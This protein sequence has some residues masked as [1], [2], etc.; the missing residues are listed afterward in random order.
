[1][2]KTQ[3]PAKRAK[4]DE[5][6]S[7]VKGVPANIGRLTAI[8]SD[9]ELRDKI[10]HYGDDMIDA[11]VVVYN[12]RAE[13]AS[14]TLIAYYDIGETVLP[15]FKAHKKG[16]AQ[17]I[18]EATGVPLGVL[19]ASM[20]TAKTYNR[21]QIEELTTRRGKNGFIATWSHV[22]TLAG[23]EDDAA[24]ERLCTQMFAN[25]WAVDEL[26]AHLPASGSGR[27]VNATG[28]TPSIPASPIACVQGLVSRLTASNNYALVL[29]EENDDGVT[30]LQHRFSDV[31]VTDSSLIASLEAAMTAVKRNVEVN[32]KAA[33]V[34]SN[35]LDAA[36]NPPKKSDAKQAALPAPDRATAK[37]I[38]TVKPVAPIKVTRAKAEQAAPAAPSVS[39]AAAAA[40]AAAKPVRKRAFD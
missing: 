25:A 24:R 40:A 23:V 11:V 32:N 20:A 21:D 14:N 22:H 4:R 26:Q 37:G 33:S 35:M 18:C 2:A 16:G 34:I 17:V 1:V 15:V 38:K 19:Y 12:R 29:L 6:V 9:K 36:K 39:A 28:R 13:A 27:G 10:N 30:Q 31:D 5:D 3:T 7:D 8:V